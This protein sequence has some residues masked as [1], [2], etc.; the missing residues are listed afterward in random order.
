MTKSGQED[1]G[2][3][4]LRKCETLVLSGSR[5]VSDLEVCSPG[6]LGLP[7]GPDC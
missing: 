4:G 2:G 5:A 1:A 3:R 7:S 6:T